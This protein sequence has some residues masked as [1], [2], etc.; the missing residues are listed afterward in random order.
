MN[1]PNETNAS[2]AILE[3]LE[4]TLSR[5]SV[6]LESLAT[7][8]ADG[9]RSEGGD[10]PAAELRALQEELRRTM[11]DRDEMVK[12]AV[13]AERQSSRLTGL[14]VALYQLHSTLDPT[15]V[16]ESIAEIATDLVGAERFALLIREGEAAAQVVLARGFDADEHLYVEGSKGPI[17]DPQVLATFED[18]VLR[19]D[20]IESQQTLATVPFRVED[21]TVAVLAI[22]EIVDHKEEALHSDRELLDLL[23]VHAASAMVAAESHT[24]AKRKL[25]TLKQLVGLLPGSETT[26]ST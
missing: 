8:E 14:Y 25:N 11:A 23:S 21:R 16:N 13:E 5:A 4:A 12:L 17:S 26:K 1:Q 9:E 22:F 18:G 20:P 24:A 15:T 6:L 3:E 10:S 19:T 2:R 7:P